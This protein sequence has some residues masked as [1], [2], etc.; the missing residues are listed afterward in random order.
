MEH[1]HHH[2]SSHNHPS[3]QNFTCPM[4]P[5]VIK[6]GPGKCPKC[7]MDL[8]PVA[9]TESKDEHHHTD[10]PAH[11]HDDHAADQDHASHAA[12]D[13]HAGHHTHDFLRRFW[14][15]LV[16]TI[17]ILLLSHMIQQWLGFEIRFPGDKYVLL[18]LSTFI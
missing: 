3:G 2:S 6:P 7:G 10:A 5:E 1:E 13:K 14:V 17:P 8:V 12:H 15:C 9:D 16:I 4:H 18:A 11:K